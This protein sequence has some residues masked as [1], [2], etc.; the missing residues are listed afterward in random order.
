MTNFLDEEPSSAPEHAPVRFRARGRLIFEWTALL[1]LATLLVCGLELSK[2][3]SRLDNPI[4]DFAMKLRRHPAPA[5][6]VIVS[7]DYPSMTRA[8]RWP[9]PRETQAAMLANIARD[10]P[11]AIGLG[12]LY[13]S[14]GTPAGDAAVRDAISK[15]PVYMPVILQTP[16][17]GKAGVMA[18]PT[19][20]IGQAAAGVGRAGATPDRDGIVRRA[21]LTTEFQGRRIPELMV[22][23]AGHSPHAKAVRARAERSDSFLKL[24]RQNDEF[25]IPFAGPTDHFDRVSAADVVDGVTP[26]GRFTGKY[27]LVGATAPGLLD[28]YPTPVSGAD[29]MPNIELEANILD[30]LLRHKL[31]HELPYGGNLAL[32]LLL[33]WAL[34]AELLWLRPTQFAYQPVGS[35]IIFGASVAA[36]VIWGVWFPP[37]TAVIVRTLVQIVWSSRR[38]QAASDYFAREL[39]ELQ[40]RAGGAVM[41]PRAGGLA[42]GDSVA[43]QM[44]LID[45]TRQRIRELRRF[46]SGVLANFPDPVFV[47]TP[48]GRII[49]FNHAGTLLGQ[50]LGRA[51]D[52]GAPLQP[53]LEDLAKAAGGKVKLWPPSLTPEGPPPRGV[54]PGGRIYEARYTPTGELEGEPRGW[55]IHLVDVT[56]LVAAM[57]QREEAMQ[58]F[59]HDMR[60]PQSA[61]LA[62][63]EHEDFRAVP[64][65]LR[66]RIEQ[67]ALRTLSLAE[68]FVRLA[69]AEAADYA[70]A[71]I[72]LFH[73]LGDAADALWAIAEAAGVRIIVEDPG[74]EFVVNADRGLLARAFINLV[75]NAVKFSPPGKIVTCSLAEATLRGRPAVACAIADEARGLSQAQQA[76]LFKRFARPPVD[77]PDSETATMGT[78]GVGLGLTVVQTVVSR[79]DGV[80]DCRSELGKGTVFTVTL[81]LCDEADPSASG[82]R[83]ASRQG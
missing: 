30:A 4:Y 50:R 56:D 2:E 79:H 3:T 45:E 26:P 47:V 42:M 77:D 70:L 34:F 29:G 83:E 15:A 25:L 44:V 65:A 59:T 38:L 53:I 78:T 17:D 68:N 75:D 8:G 9:W 80:I 35:L 76:S 43:R 63:L 71:P 36:L 81:P 13:Q 54:G 49:M 21:F 51:T 40:T 72:D 5:N 82:P 28:N 37:M 46:V 48:R 24:I 12:I 66:D 73:L 41:Q 11:L 20:A 7:I 22:L 23:V 58:L 67:N 61:I 74:R 39:A 10:H 69:Q 27:V 19:P 55:T 64:K 31:I 18:L 62:A 16:R 33:V 6:I 60:A 14:K 1:I 52:P 57:R 32:T